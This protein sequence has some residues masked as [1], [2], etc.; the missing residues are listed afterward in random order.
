MRKSETARPYRPDYCSAETLAYRLDCSERT[1]QD[2][3][4]AG[5]LP[6]PVTIGNLVRWNWEDVV[7]H[8]WAQNGVGDTGTLLRL[9]AGDE[10]SADILK[11]RTT[12][13]RLPKE[14]AADD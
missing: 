11:L 14:A 8:V 7:E 13:K 2:Y 4:S 5:C 6:K 10:Y 1:V 12:Q 9:A 3:A